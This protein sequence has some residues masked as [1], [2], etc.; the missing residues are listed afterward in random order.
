M[1]TKHLIESNITDLDLMRDGL[2]LVTLTFGI[3]L[4][5]NASFYDHPEAALG[6]LE[7]F[8]KWC[9]ADQLRYYATETMSAH[10]PVTQ[11]VL[12]M[13]PTWLKPDAPRKKWLALELKSS[14]A[15]QDAPEFKF[16]IWAVDASKQA[17]L[18]SLALPAA[19][20]NEKPGQMLEL[21]QRLCDIFPFHSGLAGYAFER[22]HYALEDSETHA[23]QASMRHP[24]IDIVRIPEDARASGG[25]AVKGV[26]WLTLLGN[27]LVTQLGGLPN[28]R[29]KFGSDIDLIES[30]NGI[31]VKAGPRPLA[32]DV[33][34]G[35]ELTPYCQVYD[36]LAPWIQTA[37]KQSVCFQL[38]D[39]FVERTHAWYARLRR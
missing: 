6:G 28:L 23:W 21:V 39:D 24:G 14:N 30:K 4:Y 31:I 34:R 17:N 26:G 38:V 8:Y 18:L 36:V 2:K 27:D 32:G 10:K 11:R 25:N 37:A 9:P 22:S 7:L 12:G 19:W 15:Y 1:N 35:Y 5:T 3:D 29:G 20:G 16:H 33:N 13:L